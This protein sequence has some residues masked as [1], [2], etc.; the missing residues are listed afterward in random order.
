[1][2]FVK[3]GVCCED[4]D[5][6]DVDMEFCF[7]DYRSRWVFKLGGWGFVVNIKNVVVLIC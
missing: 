1:M 7:G 2:L 4:G 5:C 6:G 3:Y